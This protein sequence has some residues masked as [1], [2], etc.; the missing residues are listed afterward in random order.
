M[1]NRRSNAKAPTHRDP[2]PAH[3]SSAE[4]AAEFWD[5]HD[6][7]DYEEHMK[8]VDVEIDIRK[9]TFL[10]SL[11]GDL[12]RKVRAIATEKGV[13]TEHLV[14]LWIEEKAS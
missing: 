14:N 8:D 5:I 10:I 3:F 4:E 13:P 1:S 11:D 12:Y 7:A 2:L 9:R 6:S